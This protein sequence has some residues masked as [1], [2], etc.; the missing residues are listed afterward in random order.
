MMQMNQC[1]G[2]EMFSKKIGIF[3]ITEGSGS[4][5]ELKKENNY[6]ENNKIDSFLQIWENSVS[7]KYIEYSSSE[8]TYHHSILNISHYMHFT[9]PIRR[10]V[11]IYNQLYWIQYLSIE[12]EKI[13]PLITRI[14]QDKI[15]QDTKT[16]RKLQNE[17]TLLFLL[18]GSEI[19]ITDV[20]GIVIQNINDNKSLV[21][22]PHY[23][24]ILPC[25]QKLELYTNIKC[26]IF[27]FE[28]ENDYKRKIELSI[29]I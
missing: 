18:Q 2:K 7:G 11:D 26:S 8:E 12:S 28:R 25:K 9:S 29:C 19:P 1:I 16:I 27:I 21:Y 17:C 22:L 14:N 4:E 10:K 3:R 20:D 24:C 6:S 23:K 15:N 13:S 5:S